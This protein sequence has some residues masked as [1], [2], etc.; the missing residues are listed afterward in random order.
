M[1]HELVWSEGIESDLKGISDQDLEIILKK[2]NQ[3]SENPDHFLR[4]RKLTN[5]PYYSIRAGNFRI[6]V[7]WNKEN[8]TITVLM[9]GKRD[10]I[11]KKLHKDWK[12]LE[13]HILIER[14]SNKKK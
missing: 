12:S 1:K 14:V 3:A 11:Y 2:A 8:I 9:V 4:D 13:A 6:I 5:Y 7:L 10:D